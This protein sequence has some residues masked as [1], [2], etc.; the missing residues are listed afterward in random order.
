MSGGVG[1]KIGGAR[2]CGRRFDKESLAS[3]MS[4]VVRWGKEVYLT[5]I[6]L[7]RVEVELRAGEDFHYG[8]FRQWTI[9]RQLRIS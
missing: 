8:H 9:D 3:S 6:M 7:S 5:E 2:G 1:L 4:R